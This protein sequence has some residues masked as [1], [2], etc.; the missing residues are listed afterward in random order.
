MIS[1]ETIRDGHELT[2][3]VGFS[4]SD[5]VTDSTTDAAELETSVAALEAS[6]TTSAYETAAKQPSAT[7][8]AVRMVTVCNGQVQRLH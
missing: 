3:K 7:M 1:I 5:E 8:A 2:V 4:T 6:S